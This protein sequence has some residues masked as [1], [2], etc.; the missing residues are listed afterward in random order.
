MGKAAR[1]KREAGRTAVV[2]GG[3]GA[4][5]EPYVARPFAG[6]AGETDW[7]ALREIVPAATATLTLRPDAPGIPAGAPTQATV[8]TVLPLAWP[9]LRRG[10]GTAMVALQ[11]IQSGGDPSR[12]VAQ[13]LLAALAAEPGV[14]VTGLP[15]ATAATPRLQDLLA[16]EPLDV[17]VHEDFGFWI[18]PGTELDGEAQTSLQEANA[19][20]IPTVKL[21][22][23][24]SAY[25]CR[26]GART[27]LRWLLPHEEDAATDALARLHA[28]GQDGLGEGTRLLGAFRASGLLA[29]V[30]D[31]DPGKDAGDYEEPMTAL[32]ARFEAALGDAPLTAQERRAR[33]GLLSRQLTLR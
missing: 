7:V 21:A 18:A 14:P 31:L 25:W 3:G 33:S 26:I 29:P 6:L 4:A 27:H 11:T 15:P 20:I 24:P 13:A 12:D 22:G 32:A 23:A 28:A 30:W 9:G 8:C 16:D 1:R 5:A 17:A 19:A 10:D 2:G